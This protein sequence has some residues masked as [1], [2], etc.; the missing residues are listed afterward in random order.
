[1]CLVCLACDQELPKVFRQ[2]F[3]GGIQRRPQQRTPFQE[4]V[5][6]EYV[7]TRCARNGR[8]VQMTVM[9]CERK[10]RNEK[11]RK[12]VRANEK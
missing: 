4:E 7:A 6:E 11:L 3:G 9:M 2:H 12:Y 5:Q 10:L 1:M 8:N